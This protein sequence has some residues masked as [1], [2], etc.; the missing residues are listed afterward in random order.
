MTLQNGAR[1]LI[2]AC[3]KQSQQ[4]FKIMKYYMLVKIS[5]VRSSIMACSKIWSHSYI[6]L[7]QFSF[8]VHRHLQDF[9]LVWIQFLFG[10]PG[11]S[12]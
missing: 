4:L 1:G 3:L 6:E 8:C 5:E 9:L 7:M 2:C 12:G 10:C 11:Y